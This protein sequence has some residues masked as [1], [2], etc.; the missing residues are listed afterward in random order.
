MEILKLFA[1]SIAIT[2][3]N[4]VGQDIERANPVMKC[5]IFRDADAEKV[6]NAILNF[7]KKDPDIA[8]ILQSESPLKDNGFNNM[9]AMK[10]LLTIT[11]FYREKR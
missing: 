1:L 3:L 7:L 4:V 2:A 5:V 8:Y 11:I 6:N 9:P 10:N